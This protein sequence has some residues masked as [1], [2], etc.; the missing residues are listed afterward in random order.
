M[1][2]AEKHSRQFSLLSQIPRLVSNLPTGMTRRQ[3][4]RRSSCLLLPFLLWGGIVLLDCPVRAD[5]PLVIPQPSTG[6]QSSAGTPSASASS[7]SV[8]APSSA[9]LQ[10]LIRQLSG[11]RFLDR[12]KAQQQLG[13]YAARDPQQLA[14]L[15]SS[16]D[17]EAQL[18]IVRSLEETFLANADAVG[19]Q[20]ER[21]LDTIRQSPVFAATDAESVLLGNGMLRE[22]RVRPELEKLGVYL[23][24]VNPATERLPPPTAPF[25]GVGF[26]PPSMLKSIL[27]SEDWSGSPEELW[28]FKRLIHLRDLTLY[29]VRGNGMT[30]EQLAELSGEL[31]GLVIAT[32]GA[33]L[34]IQANTVTSTA[35]VSKVIP[36]SAA[37]AAD[38]RPYDEILMIDD[39]EVRNFSHLI[40]LLLE[41]SPGDQVIMKIRREGEEL[42]IPVKLGSWKRNPGTD[43]SNT[44][45][46]PPFAGPLGQSLPDSPEFP[47]PDVPEISPHLHLH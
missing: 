34:G 27:V 45:P 23:T 1:W 22:S 29:T 10:T 4:L 14:S 9:E 16:V 21:A 24:Y 37:A 41:F 15:C 36:H 5:S 26:G 20:A 12:V 2:T 7:P 35:Q 6:A 18:R 32:R 13:A 28:Q 42:K 38:L 47:Q 3:S 8:S 44:P 19:D 40:A 11:D 30:S 46:P 39:R 43:L 33:C 31:T 25:S 17:P